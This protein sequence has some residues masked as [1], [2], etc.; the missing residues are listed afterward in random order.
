MIP[1]EPYCYVRTTGR[2]TGR[3]HEIEIWFAAQ[4]DT[5]YILS[6]GRDRSDW[7]KNIKKQ[8]RVPVRIGQSTFAGH[9][10]IIDAASDEDA[11]AR[12]LV[13]AKYT[14]TNDDLDEWGRTALAVAIDLTSS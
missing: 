3:P 12:Q 11:R 6:G 13:L 1:D 4:G 10:R 9:A 8:P 14:P 7:V 2:V 5:I